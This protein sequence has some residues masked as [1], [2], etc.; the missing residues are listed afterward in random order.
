[1]VGDGAND[2]AALKTAWVGIS[3]RGGFEA[4]IRSADALLI[5]NSISGLDYL[6]RLGHRIGKILPL[7]LGISLAY[8][9]IGISLVIFGILG[10]LGAAILMP[11]SA[12]T[13]LI[14][15]YWGIQSVPVH[16]TR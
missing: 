7:N 1:M 3:V 16:L 4:S 13:V 14:I 15:G 11:L 6:L 8:N 12:A 2:A 5:G 10:P 9:L